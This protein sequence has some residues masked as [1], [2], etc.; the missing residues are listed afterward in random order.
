MNIIIILLIVVVFCVIA[1]VAVSSSSTE[2]S[3]EIVE[4][5][6]TFAP[7]ETTPVPATTM[8]TTFAPASSTTTLAPAS[9]T[10]MPSGSIDLNKNGLLTGS[11]NNIIREG[12]H[13]S[14]PDGKFRLGMQTDGNLH[15]YDTTTTKE[16]WASNST[17]TTNGPYYAFFHDDGT[18]VIYNKNGAQTWV[19]SGGDPGG[20]PPYKLLMLIDGNLAIADKNEWVLDRYG[21]RT[22][23]VIKGKVVSGDDIACYTNPNDKFTC[24]QGCFDNETCNQYIIS[25]SH[26]NYT[27]NMC[28]SKNTKQIPTDNLQWNTY[29]RYHRWPVSS[30]MISRYI[31]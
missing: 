21:S 22:F 5:T 8:A 12:Y 17:D 11:T 3:I 29:S 4:T 13:I 2:P 7:E 18:F 25:T 1:A 28:C 14:S 6:T 26:N 19:M 27:P 20:V 23:G 30:N 16:I 15:I 31:V 10:T 9:S 24:V